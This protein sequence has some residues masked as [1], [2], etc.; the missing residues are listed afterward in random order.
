MKSFKVF[1]LYAGGGGEFT[2]VYG[3]ESSAVAK[4]ES[5]GDSG[6]SC[7]MV[8]ISSRREL[9]SLVEGDVENATWEDLLLGRSVGY[10]APV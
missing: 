7:R 6:Y 10:V 8:T 9:E 4:G 5:F 2:G 1:C 3:S